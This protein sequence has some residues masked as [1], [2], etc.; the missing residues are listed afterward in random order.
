M[1][2]ATDAPSPES[3][4]FLVIWQL[5]ARRRS[6]PLSGP[7]PGPPAR[8]R[9]STTSWTDLANANK[10]RNT[11]RAY[12]GDLLAFAAHHDG[13]IGG[14]TAAPVPG[15]PRGDRGAG[16]VD[17]QAQARRRRLRSAGGRSGTNLAGLQPDG[18][19][20]HRHRAEDAAQARRSPPTSRA[21]LDAICPAATQEGGACRRPARPGA[22]RD[23][24]HLRRP[25]VGGLRDVRRGPGP[26]PG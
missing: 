22:V 3:L 18:P 5:T 16:P 24:L 21:V 12:R 26:A 13:E 11:I 2:P 7:F 9:T 23:R 1:S 10:P 4:R 8:R 14:I 17:P 15:V 20:R 19:H 25:C 6:G